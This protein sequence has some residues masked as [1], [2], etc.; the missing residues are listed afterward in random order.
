MSGIL[1]IATLATALGCGLNAGIFFAFSSFVMP[2]LKRLPAAHG[3]AAMQSINKLAVTPA[4]MAALFGTAVACLA[5]V[6]WAVISSGERPAALLLAGGGLYL[7]GTIG[8]TIA[9]NGPAQRRARDTT[10]PGRRCGEPL[11]RVPHEVDRLEPRADPRRPGSCCRAH[12][13]TPCLEAPG[14][15]GSIEAATKVVE[16]A[17]RSM[18]IRVSNLWAGVASERPSKGV[19]RWLD[20]RNWKSR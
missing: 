9:C 7:V 12:H 13:R 17:T 3:I 1:Y 4:F 19:R 16:G 18:G 11:G 5:L 2:A 6:A 15:A 20:T 14:R 8:V 10:P